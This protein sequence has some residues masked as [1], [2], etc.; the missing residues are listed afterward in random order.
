L[1]ARLNTRLASLTMQH[2]DFHCEMIASG[3]AVPCHGGLGA[4]RLTYP[5]GLVSLVAEGG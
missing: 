5:A 3:G 2:R 1:Y 4:A